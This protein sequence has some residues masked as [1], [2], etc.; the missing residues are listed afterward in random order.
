MRHRLPAGIIQRLRGSTH[1]IDDEL[2]DFALL[3][4]LHPLIRIVRSARPV[5]ARN[6]SCNARGQIGYFELLHATDTAAAIQQ[7]LPCSF[8]AARERRHHSEPC[9]DDASHLLLLPGAPAW[10]DGNATCVL[11]PGRQSTNRANASLRMDF[12]RAKRFGRSGHRNKP[13]QPGGIVRFQALAFFS[14]NLTASPTVRIVSAASSGISQPNSSSKAMTS[15]TVSRLSAPRSSMKLAPS[16]TLSAST[17]KCST[18]IFLTRSPM[19][20]IV[21]T[22]C[23]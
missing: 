23:P 8:N 21:A 1:C 9:D 10:V 13:D 20:L 11:A 5:S 4:G 19:S 14:R 16:V 18:T 7:T 22:S 15:S 12:V 2:V 3:L 17:P 6:L